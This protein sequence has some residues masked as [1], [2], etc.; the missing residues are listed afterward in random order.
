[1]R[2]IPLAL[3]T[4][5]LATACTAPPDDQSPEQK[6]AKAAAA[7][8][9][10]A[11]SIEGVTY[12]GTGCEGS[13]TTSLSPDKQ[14]ATSLFSA[15]VA[16]VGPGSPPEAATRNCLVMMQINVPSGWSYSLE[17]VDYRGFTALEREVTASRQAL[18]MI[19]G[20]PVHV[21]PPARFTGEIEDN[22]NHSD[23]GPDAPGVWSP[24]GGG[25][26]L[27]IATQTEVK[28]GGRQG[29]A[30]QLTVD[31]MDTELQWRRCQ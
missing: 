17:S 30:G 9:A 7:A 6:V 8:P 28:T 19:S 25:Q 26:V 5:L 16:S 2:K 15:F 20:S 22:Y 12:T 29:R 10:G 21:T 4:A 11:G 13:A 31:S 3:L 23:V 18:Y 14:V 24:C 27:W 1:M